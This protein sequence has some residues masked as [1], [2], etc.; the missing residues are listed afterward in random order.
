GRKVGRPERL[1]S[2]TDSQR[3]TL[4]KVRPYRSESSPGL[5]WR[6]GAGVQ[7]LQT[8][9]IC[10]GVVVCTQL[11]PNRGFVAPGDECVD[12]PIT[13]TVAEVLIGVALASPVVH[14]V[15]QTK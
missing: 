5:E 15:R 12:Q 13:A 8:D 3:R 6:F 14:V 4:K 11:P 7:H 10:A 9:V 2:P 1:T